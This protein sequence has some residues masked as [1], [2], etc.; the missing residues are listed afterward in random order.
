MQASKG[1]VFNLT[2]EEMKKRFNMPLEKWKQLES[3]GKILQAPDATQEM[4]DRK[5][6]IV[7]LGDVCPCGTKLPYKDCCY[8]KMT[9]GQRKKYHRKLGR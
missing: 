2:E 1:E 5:D 7:Y 9:K 6:G 8:K 3:E 4:L